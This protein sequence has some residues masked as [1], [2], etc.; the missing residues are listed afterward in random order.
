MPYSTYGIHNIVISI[1]F[2]R[3]TIS[4]TTLSIR[5]L[6]II[7]AFVYFRA[8]VFFIYSWIKTKKETNSK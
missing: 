7:L 2:K 1:F 8:T 3:L 4:Y 6:K 5:G